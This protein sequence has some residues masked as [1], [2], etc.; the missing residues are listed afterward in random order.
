LQV[1]FLNGFSQFFSS[2]R[3]WWHD[4]NVNLVL[5]QYPGRFWAARHHRP[6][7]ETS[8][9]LVLPAHGGSRLY[10]G[11]GSYPSKQDYHLDGASAH[12]FDEALY[13]GAIL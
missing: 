6:L 10:Q 7:I 12:I 2:K 13:L 11:S 3:L 1:Q 5:S 8:D 4:I 9:E